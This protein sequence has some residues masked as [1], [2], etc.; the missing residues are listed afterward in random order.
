MN[1]VPGA[2]LNTWCGKPAQNTASLFSGTWTTRP[3]KKY[4]MLPE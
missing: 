2:E 1:V 4:R 3:L